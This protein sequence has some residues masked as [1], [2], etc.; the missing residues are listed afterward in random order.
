MTAVV[1]V[2]RPTRRSTLVRTATVALVAVPGLY[3]FNPNTSR[4]PLC[5]LHAMTGLWCPLCGVTRASHALLH[6]QLGTALQDNLL[7]VLAL[8]CWRWHGGAG[9]AQRERP[10]CCPVRCWPRYCYWA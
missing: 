10:G 4:I 6:G 1:S 2:D 7:F 5:P 8:P 3:L 9:P